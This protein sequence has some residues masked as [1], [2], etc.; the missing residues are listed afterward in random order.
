MFKIERN[1]LIISVLVAVLTIIQFFGIEIFGVKPNF[2]LAGLITAMFFLSFWEGIFVAAFASLVF[3]FSP[4]A[5]YETAVFF[6]IGIAAALA[7]RY[8]PW[9]QAVGVM[10]SVVMGTVLL[11]LILFIGEIFS[12]GFFKELVYNLILGI[13]LFYFMTFIKSAKTGQP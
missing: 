4:E 13:L 3:K 10:I 5:S 2:A 1:F 11:Y 12:A 8:F 7:A 6:G 9:R